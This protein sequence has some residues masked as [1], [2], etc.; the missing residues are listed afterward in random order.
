VVEPSYFVERISNEA[1]R[2]KLLALIDT[3]LQNAIKRLSQ[4]ATL[5][6]PLQR[7]L[8]HPADEVLQLFGAAGAG[9]GAAGG[10]GIGMPDSGLGG[11]LGAPGGIAELPAG[12]RNSAG[13]G[14][15]STPEPDGGTA[16]LTMPGAA[17]LRIHLKISI[18]ALLH[19]REDKRV[20]EALS[21][22]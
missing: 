12:L 15:A 3:E 8:G 10:S 11:G 6:Q 14:A 2:E 5:K 19:A 18:L 7:L 9:A 13:V 21:Q 4:L 20:N 1:E 16:N 22:F 17:T